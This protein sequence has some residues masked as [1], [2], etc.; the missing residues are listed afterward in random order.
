M[1]A[2]RPRFPTLAPP[3]LLPESRRGLRRHLSAPRFARKRGSVPPPRPSGTARI[4][5]RPG[6]Q[7][8]VMGIAARGGIEVCALIASTNRRVASSGSGVVG[9]SVIFGQYPCRA[10]YA[11]ERHRRR[12]LWCPASPGRSKPPAKPN[13][14]APPADRG[15]W[16]SKNESC[17][18]IHLPVVEATGGKT[19]FTS[20]LPPA[21][22]VHGFVLPQPSPCV[23]PCRQL[24]Y[25]SCQ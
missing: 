14:N 20:M 10:D 2:E 4:T 24:G 22:G 16:T 1:V 15:A 23:K 3:D 25:R 7:D 19:A 13:L 9:S 17:A 8:R 12:P 6:V 11:G 21:L 5:D 18:H